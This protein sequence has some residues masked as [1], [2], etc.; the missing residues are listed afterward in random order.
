MT[1]L[2]NIWISPFAKIVKKNRIEAYRS[3]TEDKPIIV[4]NVCINKTT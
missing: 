4:Y 2:S 3:Q 1:L